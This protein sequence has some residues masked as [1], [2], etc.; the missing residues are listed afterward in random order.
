MEKLAQFKLRSRELQHLRDIGSV[1]AWD[2]E[3]IMPPLGAEFRAQQRA[4]LAGIA[5]TK[6][7]DPVLSE[8]LDELEN[9]NLQEIDQASV[10]EL[11]RQHEKAVRVPEALV[12]ELTEV[13]AIAHEH[14]VKARRDSDFAIFEPWLL[15]ITKL[16][17]EE[18]RCIALSDSAY[19]TLMDEFEPAAKEAQLEAVFSEVRSR[20]IQLLRKIEDSPVRPKSL[21][22]VYPVKAQDTFGRKILTAMG[23]DWNAGRLDTSTHPF[24]VGLNPNDVRITTRHAEKYFTSALF[25]MIHEGGHALYEQGLDATNYGL[26]VCDSTSLGMHESQSR[27][28]ENQIGRSRPFWEHWFPQLQGFFPGQLDHL[29]LDDFVLAINRVS[30]SFIRV[31]ADEVTYGLHIIL[32]YEIEKKLMA[33]EINVTDLPEVWNSKMEEYLGIRPSSEAEGVLQDTHWSQGLIGYFPT[34]LLG[35][36]YGAQIMATASQEIPDLENQ[37]SSGKLLE[38]REWLQFNVHTPGN[39][40]SASDLILRIT[41]EDLSANYFLDY[42]DEKYSGLYQL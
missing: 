27:L 37:V 2:Q 15:R 33:E 39:A 42:L 13:A 23:L 35:N 11:R 24:C 3:V 14:W 1:L 19:E 29:T 21:E 10:R 7:I 36:L 41:G 28:W 30:P 26:P 12:R 25:G 16:K 34:Y 20:L 17:K 9:A 38:L 6:L 32:R 8:L 5:H 4:T 22:G 40:L 18:A 31:E